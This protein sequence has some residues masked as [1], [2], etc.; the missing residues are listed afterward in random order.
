ML[1]LSSHNLPA[2]PDLAPKYLK[3]GLTKYGATTKTNDGDKQ[4]KPSQHISKS[5]T[6]NRSYNPLL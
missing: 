3:R 1:G 5:L 6:R 2:T 4:G